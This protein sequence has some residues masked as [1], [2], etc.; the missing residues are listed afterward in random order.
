MTQNII[1]FNW[2]EMRVVLRSF[3]RLAMPCQDH[4]PIPP[5]PI[6]AWEFSIWAL[7]S[8]QWI[9]REEK[10]ESVKAGACRWSLR[11]KCLHAAPAH[12]IIKKQHEAGLFHL[13]V[14]EEEQESSQMYVMCV[15]C[16]SASP[17]PATATL[18]FQV[19]SLSQRR[20]GTVY[21]IPR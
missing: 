20:E 16:M 4:F 10:D 1:F 8:R 12:T 9:S 14:L 11:Q 18:A 7:S 19:P 2:V 21:M 13:S 17:P 6:P 15:S 5:P 3:Y